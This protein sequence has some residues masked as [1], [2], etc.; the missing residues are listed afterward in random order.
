MDDKFEQHE[1]SIIKFSSNLFEL[2]SLKK[3]LFRYINKHI[4]ILKWK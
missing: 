3:L 2:K 1:V 4:K